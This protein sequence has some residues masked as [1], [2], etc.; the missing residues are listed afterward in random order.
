MVRAYV[1]HPLRTAALTGFLGACVALNA[2]IFAVVDGDLFK[3]LPFPGADRLVTI[4]RDLRT[5]GGAHPGSVSRAQVRQLQHAPGTEAVAAFTSG[6]IASDRGMDEGLRSVS[7]TAGFFALLGVRPVI[8]RSLRSDDR[9]DA[10]ILPVVI[11]EALWRTWFSADAGVEGRTVMLGGVRCLIV[12]VAP[13]GFDFPLGT[14]VWN[15]LDLDA[16]PQ[17]LLSVTAIAR[18]ES[19]HS[20]PLQLA[21][22]PIACEPLRRTFSPRNAWALLLVLSASTTLMIMTLFQVAVLELA[23]T[24]VRMRELG[25]RLAVGATRWMLAAEFMWYGAAMGAGALATAALLLPALLGWLIM[26]LP[27]ELSTGQ[28]ISVDGRALGFSAVLTLGV[29]VSFGIIPL[30]TLARVDPA[31]L[32]RGVTNGRRRV[33]APWIIVIAQVAFSTALAYLAL[34]TVRSMVS[35]ARVDLGY[36]PAG[37]VV[38]RLPDHRS[39]D[40]SS[41]IYDEMADRVRTR[42]S[43]ASVA[44][45]D[46]R[47]LGGPTTIASVGRGDEGRTARARMVSVTPGY[48]RAMGIAVLGG[49]DFDARDSRGA[50]FA[51]IVNRPLARRLGM[52][53]W[54]DGERLVLSGLPVALVGTVGDAV[55][56]RPD[57]P[58]QDVVFVPT[59][60]WA[61]PA[62]LLARSR[63]GAGEQAVSEVSAVL[64]SMAPPGSFTI[65]ALADE[66]R[67]VTAGYRARMTLLLAMGTVGIALCAAGVYGG[68][69]YAWTQARHSTAIR[70]ALGGTPARVRLHVLRVLAARTGVGL[71]IGIVAG[72][73]AGRLGAAFLFGIA[74]TDGLSA[75]CALGIVAAACCVAA[76]SPTIRIGRVQPSEVL[77]DQ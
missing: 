71:L 3:P 2:A 1:K 34:L 19:G 55:L 39:P 10:Q 15:L 14:S 40:N 74:P 67:R 25:V 37:L 77:R 45:S 20:C 9:A 28:R 54:H 33:T 30:Q 26:L 46:G 47:P 66:A 5:S 51:V 62:Y 38:A 21:G 76:A 73:L 56:T 70:L 60:Q 58:D 13:P 41:A 72:A 6:T 27:A 8:G 75:A 22:A 36:D 65:R 64:R 32:F 17:D 57:D 61:P 50:D 53:Q 52:S 59:T 63:P 49:R 24:V 69:T 43:V 7:V 68:V 11:G 42:P 4:G 16:A 18:L 48:F 29:I 35:V 44:G 23:R 12:G 31:H